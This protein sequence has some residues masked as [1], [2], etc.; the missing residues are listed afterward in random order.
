MKKL[1]LIALLGLF[2]FVS[3]AQQAT[4]YI[5]AEG[6]FVS[7]STDYVLTDATVAYTLFKAPQHWTTTQDFLC[8]LDSLSGNH[9]NVEVALFGRKFNTSPWVAIGSAVDWAGTTSD[10]TIVIS[11]TTA[12]RYRDYKVQYTGTGTG[13]TTIDL[14]E[15]KLFRE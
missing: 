5:S 8:N 11:N 14:Q 9:T 10:T 15:L 4:A 2:T 1:I 7:V 3:N 13:T 6:S 12:N